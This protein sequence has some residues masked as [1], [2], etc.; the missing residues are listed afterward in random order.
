M[1]TAADDALRAAL[2]PLNAGH[3]LGRYELLAPV[4][5]GGMAVVWAA[6]QSGTRGFSKLVAVKTMLPSLAADPRF[7]RMFLREAELSARVRHPNVCPILDL[8]EQDGTLYLV[9]EWVDGE[10]LA[11]LRAL[12]DDAGRAIPVAVA[13]HAVAQAARGL[14]AAHTLV[15]DAGAPAGIVHRDVSP[16]NVLVRRDGHVLVVDFGVA[17]AMESS[18]H[19]TQS[20][21]IKGKI[22]YLAPEQ[23]EG[24]PLDARADVFAL[25]VVLYE[26]TTGAHPFRGTTDV[27]TLLRISG[28]EAPPPPVEL[29]EGF[30]PALSD[31][32]MKALAKDPVVRHRSAA[33]LARELEAIGA[34]GG[35][36][37]AER[38]AAFVEEL[39]AGHRTA[40]AADLARAVE[41][42]DERR[43]RREAEPDGAALA[44]PT[45][46]PSSRSRTAVVAAVAV[47]AGVGIGVSW[48]R[49][50][51]PADGEPS[52]AARLR[53]SALPPLATSAPSVATSGASATAEAASSA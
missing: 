50:S 3:T 34:A 22:A 30:P 41:L 40:L 12:A 36:D 21:T 19:A 5:R 27:A 16:H 51:A 35:V 14:H 1:S 42:A 46:R 49:S 8:G 9:M 15:D 18:D 31:A 17:K 32:I 6:R 2:G 24:R 48:M 11:A 47:A 38:T 7:E 43:A 25:G 39:G 45:R 4:G 13:A 23:A 52:L 29:V 44:A 53:A 20:G 10:S 37:A 26:L 28:P 33:D